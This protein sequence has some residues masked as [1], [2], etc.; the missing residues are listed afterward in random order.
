MGGLHEIHE[1]GSRGG[2]LEGE[3]V[4]DLRRS[5]AIH[6][7]PYR[8]L[9][10]LSSKR[11]NIFAYLLEDEPSNIPIPLTF[12]PDDEDIT[13][14]GQSGPGYAR[15]INAREWSVGNPGL[16]AVDDIPSIGF[17]SGGFHT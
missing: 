1:D 6:S 8:E 12:S 14:H 2:G 13:A 4:L 9:R 17:L 3:L 16:A 10:I 11:E 15:H 7:L 5:Q